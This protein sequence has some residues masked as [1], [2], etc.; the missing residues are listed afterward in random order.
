MLHH[1]PDPGPV[2][3]AAYRAL[4]PGGNRL[5]W[6]YGR[7]G[8][9]PYP[10]VVE[11]L[12]K[13]TAWLPHRT[14]VGLAC[15]MGLGLD[16]YIGLCRFLPLAMCSYMREVLAKFTPGVRRLTIY[17]QLN[18][19]YGKCY[20]RNEARALLADAGLVDVALY[21]RH[22]YSWIVLGRRPG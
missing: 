4:K 17:D 13:I 3:E 5:V 11:P 6:F 14:L 18:P 1:I 15:L 16:A 12:R 21:H 9:E 22:G 10:R 2:L 8:N 19:A 20:T 7:E